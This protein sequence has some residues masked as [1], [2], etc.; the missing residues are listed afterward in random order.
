[1]ATVWLGGGPGD[2][3]PVCA[4]TGLPASETVRVAGR[5]APSWVAPMVLVGFLPWLLA[6]AGASRRY[7]IEVPLTAD[8]WRRFRMFRSAGLTAALT[9]L[10]CSVIAA[11]TGA[12]VV[13]V[14]LLV[15]V[16]VVG[17][18]GLLVNEW[19][20]WFGVRLSP[21]G[22]YGLTRVHPRFA[23]AVTRLPR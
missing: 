18:A 7:E 13:T 5:A 15:G 14:L 6:R 22:E 9:G 17:G 2:L 21:E 12:A 16:A 4:K 20:N 11:G 3:P 8:A 19:V 23:D 1:M 10:A